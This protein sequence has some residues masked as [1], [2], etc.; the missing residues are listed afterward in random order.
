MLI[1]DFNKFQSL[2]TNVFAFYKQEISEF[3]MDV[4]WES[5]KIYDFDSVKSALNRHCV[6]PDNGQYLPKPA[7]VVKLLQGTSSDTAIVAWTKVE[8]AISRV[9]A[10]ASVVF[11]DAIIQKV[12]SDMGSWSGLCHKNVDEM[13]FVAKEFQQ[14]Y[15]HYKTTGKVTNHPK[16]LIGLAEAANQLQGFKSEPPVL[17]GDIDSAMLVMNNGSNEVSIGFSRL[18]LT[19]DAVS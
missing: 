15:R 14:R 5:M 19:N 11:D 10:Y 9:G 3:A 18:A 16:V 17:V 4:W 2:M 1:N 7:D 6:N 8:K 12:I 13:P